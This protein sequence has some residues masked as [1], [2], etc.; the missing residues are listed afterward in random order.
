[1][2]SRPDP[3]EFLERDWRSFEVDNVEHFA[4]LR[5]TQGLAA[6]L[7]IGDELRHHAASHCPGWP[8]EQSR[9]DDR[10]AHLRLMEALDRVP[11]ARR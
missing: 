5:R 8:G 9:A 6:I 11:A 2:Q 10:A 4:A 1:M 7:A 3:S